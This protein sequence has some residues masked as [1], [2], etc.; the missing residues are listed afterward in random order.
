MYVHGITPEDMVL[1]Q[2]VVIVDTVSLKEEEIAAWELPASHIRRNS[3]R[4]L[5]LV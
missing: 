1:T 4:P 2:I 5:N 3:M